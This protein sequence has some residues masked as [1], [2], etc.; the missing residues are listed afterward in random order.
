LIKIDYEGAQIPF[1]E[2][3]P[4]MTPPMTP[5]ITPLLSC[6]QVLEILYKTDE[7]EEFISPDEAAA[8][9]PLG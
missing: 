6:A 8:A 9:V 7:A 5:T 2:K 4:L 3:V 1:P